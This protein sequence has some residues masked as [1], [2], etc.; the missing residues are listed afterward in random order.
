MV[1]YI[2]SPLPY[3]PA[4]HTSSQLTD[5]TPIL[6]FHFHT[7]TTAQNQDSMIHQGIKY[8][9]LRIFERIENK[10]KQHPSSTASE[11]PKQ[12]QRYPSGRDGGLS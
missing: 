11:A 5:H 4:I 7:N 1:W 10:V 8:T 3:P 2:L 6:P 9:M 12:C